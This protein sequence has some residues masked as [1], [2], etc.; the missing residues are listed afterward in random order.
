M[1]CPLI[2]H[3]AGYR[4]LTYRFYTHAWCACARTKAS[5]IHT[6]YSLPFLCHP[7]TR[8]LLI[9]DWLTSCEGGGVQWNEKKP[10]IK[11][12]KGFAAY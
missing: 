12:P 4:T 8:F 10:I 1:H 6:Y 3:D 7:I 5:C 9:N 11:W 2:S